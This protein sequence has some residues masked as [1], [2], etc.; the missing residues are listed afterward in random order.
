L[1][2]EK[3][4][5]RVTKTLKTKPNHRYQ[6]EPPPSAAL[7]FLPFSLPEASR[8]PIWQKKPRPAAPSDWFWIFFFPGHLTLN[9]TLRN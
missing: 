9:P 2:K 5:K 8:R 4:K 3:R 6:K 7:G 1:K